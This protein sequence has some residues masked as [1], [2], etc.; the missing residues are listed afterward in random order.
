MSDLKV[1]ELKAHLPAKDIELSKRFYE[2]LGFR[3]AWG[4]D[5][6]VQL[7]CSG[8]SFLL[9]NFYVKEFAENLQMHLLVDDVD[10]W[11]QRVQDKQIV[12]RYGQNGV[13]PEPP[14][15]RPWGLRD[16]VL[17]DPAGVLWRIA[18]DVPAAT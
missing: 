18:Q 1:V 5:S 9:T 11:W 7:V 8:H 14:E 12:A 16:F 15:L 17:Q 2:D 4:D 13:T 10:A 3:V 6:M